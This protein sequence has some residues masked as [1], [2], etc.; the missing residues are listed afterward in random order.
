MPKSYWRNW[1]KFIFECQMCQCIWFIVFWASFYS[2]S[3]IQL[4]IN[5]LFIYRF[6]LKLQFIK[7]MISPSRWQNHY[8]F[9][10]WNAMKLKPPY[11][12][13]TIGKTK[14]RYLL[15]ML[16]WIL[17]IRV[18][19]ALIKCSIIQHTLKWGKVNFSWDQIER[20]R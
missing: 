9:A 13:V 16:N 18:L 12:S 19:L 20:K 8:K 3:T 1:K 4:S 14:Q 15:Y 10:L 17:P 6:I 7:L 2:W 5:C 11:F